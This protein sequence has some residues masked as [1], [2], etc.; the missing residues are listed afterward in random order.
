MKKIMLFI[1]KIIA[2]YVLMHTS[3]LRK[4]YTIL[5]RSC[6]RVCTW[7]LCLEDECALSVS[8]SL[9]PGVGNH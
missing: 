9:P 6:A 8:L 1:S 5:Y 2:D 7:F 4:L 3:P